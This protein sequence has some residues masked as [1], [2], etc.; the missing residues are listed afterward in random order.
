MNDVRIGPNVIVAAGAVIT[1]D[2]PP[3]VVVGG[4]P[5]KV[6]C[7]L[8]DYMSRRQR[9]VYPRELRPSGQVVSE[10]LSHFLWNEFARKRS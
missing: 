6:I 5:A 4:V 1:K 2:V 7:G 9:T 10:Q 3:G 8:D